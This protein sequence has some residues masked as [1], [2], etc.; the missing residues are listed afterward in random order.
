MT[1]ILPTS[2]ICRNES[3]TQT[4]RSRLAWRKCRMSRAPHLLAAQL[5]EKIEMT[6][7]NV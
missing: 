1:S 7:Q 3:L 4:P 5:K 2:L 6:S